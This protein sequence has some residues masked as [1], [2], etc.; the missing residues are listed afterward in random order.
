MK[1]HIAICLILVGLSFVY[2]SQAL[3]PINI[4]R[5]WDINYRSPRWCTTKTQITSWAEGGAH[6]RGVNGDNTE[7]NPLRIWQSDQNAVAMLD[8]FD[9][10]S[11]LTKKL[12]MLEMI[13]GNGQVDNDVRGHLFFDGNL[14]YRVGFGISARC[15]LPRNFSLAVHVP[16]YSM[17]LNNVQIQ[18]RTG[19]ANM[20]DLAVRQSLTNNFID[21]V[22]M[23][24]PTLNLSGWKR[25]GLGDVVFMG[26]WLREFPQKKPILKC[27]TLNARLGAITPTGVPANADDIFSVPFGCDNSSG[28]IAGGGLDVNWW[29]L[30]RAGFDVELI[31]LFGNTRTRR[32]KV[33]EGQ[34]EH[35]FLAKVSAHKDYGITRR[36]NL[37]LEASHVVGGLSLRAAYQ[38]W[39]HGEDKLTLC[40]NKFSSQIAN[41]AQNLQ[42]WTIHQGIFILS[43]DFQCHMDECSLFQ[44][45]ISVFY[46]YPFNGQRAALA[47]TYGLTFTLNF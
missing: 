26:E 15:F 31:H 28:I 3:F 5:P 11:P 46:K 42:E 4:H 47:H 21:T 38:F 43:Y 7:V 6:E 37:F 40:T 1:R 13:C 27:V 19:T 17:R 39:H 14:N 33:A 24:D 9:A 12:D 8:G 2:T 23:L 35:L 22:H 44:P 36:Y 20:C 34:T 25:S 18:D 29:N 32:V 10:D 30:M 45:H 41:T 16:F